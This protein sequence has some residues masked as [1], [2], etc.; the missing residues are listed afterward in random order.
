MQDIVRKEVPIP[1]PNPIAYYQKLLES[2]CGW[3]SRDDYFYEEA[4]NKLLLGIAS[5]LYNKNESVDL[6]ALL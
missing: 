5:N 3:T 1:D 4:K 6:T 2:M